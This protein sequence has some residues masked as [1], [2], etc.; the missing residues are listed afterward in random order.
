MRPNF[1]VE[2]LAAAV[3]RVH[4][5]GARMAVHAASPEAIDVALEAGV[6]SIEHG[7]GLR[8][9]HIAAMAARGVVLVPTLII[10]PAAEGLA[11]ALGL[12][13]AATADLLATAARHPE[14]VRRAAAAG[15][16]V[17]AGT[18]AGMGPHGMIREEIRL[19]G[20]AGLPQEAALAAGSWV[21]RRFL[22]LPGIEEGAPADL[23]AYEDDPRED[24]EALARPAF[25]MLDGRPRA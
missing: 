11:T 5:V 6:D 10:L 2:A 19:L 22:G 23:V 12:T 17:L 24:P 7:W 14:M 13:P 9:D 4:A 25:I 8:D 15:V 18:D 20:D 21:A 16:Q 1:R 3:R